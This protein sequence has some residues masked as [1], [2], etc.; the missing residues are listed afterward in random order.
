V[1]PEF[2][3]FEQSSGE[4]QQYPFRACVDDIVRR[5]QTSDDALVACVCVQ[6]LVYIVAEMN[7]S[8]G[9][10]SITSHRRISASFRDGQLFDIFQM[11]LAMLR[12]VHENV[13]CLADPNNVRARNLCASAVAVV[14]DW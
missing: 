14:A 10:A 1:H 4:S 9:L 7:Q 8:Q 2:T 13:K 12:T 3:P 5:T 6:L 11:C